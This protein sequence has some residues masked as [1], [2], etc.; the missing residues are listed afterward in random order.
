MD[1]KKMAQIFRRAQRRLWNGSFPRGN[2][3]HEY[4]C[5]AVGGVCY[6][7]KDQ[8][9]MMKFIDQLG[10][11]CYSVHQ[12]KEFPWGTPERQGARFLWLEWCALMCDEEAV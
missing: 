10:C 6:T 3:K 9:E 4:S 2:A 1:K 11:D 12:F 7:A 8:A 5:D